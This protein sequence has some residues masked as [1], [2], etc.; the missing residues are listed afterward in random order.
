MADTEDPQVRT[1]LAT[2]G[3]GTYDL[4]VDGD[5][6]VR[7]EVEDVDQEQ[8]FRA[9]G[10]APSGRTDRL[11]E[12]DEPGGALYLHERE[13]EADDWERVGEVTFAEQA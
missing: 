7:M 10:T 2:Q 4:T 9:H 13:D 6:L 3:A 5:E 8:L 11:V 12:P 1:F